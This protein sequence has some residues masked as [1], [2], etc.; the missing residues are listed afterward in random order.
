MIDANLRKRIIKLHVKALNDR[1][2]YK[3]NEKNVFEV[4]L[5]KEVFSNTLKESLSDTP[6]GH[7]R[8]EI[9]ELLKEFE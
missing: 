3:I 6:T 2:F 5:L 4:D 1:G 8:T 7:V 9:E